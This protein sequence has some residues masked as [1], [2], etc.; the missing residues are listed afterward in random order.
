LLVRAGKASLLF[1]AKSV[2][3]VCEHSKMRRTPLV[4]S[5]NIPANFTPAIY[6]CLEGTKSH[7]ASINFLYDWATTAYKHQGYRPQG[8]ANSCFEKE[9][10]I[11]TPSKV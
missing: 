2:I 11:L 4:D 6:L 5:F 7:D 1:D 3:L 8:M 9:F 10:L